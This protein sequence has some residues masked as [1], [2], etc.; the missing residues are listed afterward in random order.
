MVDYYPLQTNKLLVDL[1]VFPLTPTDVETGQ[2]F[3][4]PSRDLLS[5]WWDL[6]HSVGINVRLSPGINSFLFSFVDIWSVCRA[7]CCKHTQTNGGF[8]RLS[9]NSFTT[10]SPA[11]DS[12]RNSSLCFWFLYDIQKST[13]F[14]LQTSHLVQA[15]AWI[16]HCLCAERRLFSESKI[17]FST[18]SP[19]LLS[20]LVVQF[21]PEALFS[22]RIR[23][24][25]RWWGETQKHISLQP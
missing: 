13:L 23:D 11:A 5:T 14:L 17:H 22:G 8:S 15:P 20:S 25:E 12:D 4:K 7:V 1:L 24:S 18:L 3:E 21:V 19:L 9:L 2:T 6:S 10:F 16:I